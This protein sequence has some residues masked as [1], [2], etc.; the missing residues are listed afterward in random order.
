MGYCFQAIIAQ[1]CEFELE[2]IAG[3]HAVGMPAQIE[4]DA[5][6]AYRYDG[7]VLAKAEELNV[8]GAITITQKQ[9]EF[10]FKVNLASQLLVIQSCWAQALQIEQVDTGSVQGLSRS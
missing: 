9:D 3:V 4:V 1:V 2:S 8:P 7:E 10:L 5:P 6:E